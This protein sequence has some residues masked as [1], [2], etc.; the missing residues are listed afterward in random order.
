MDYQEWIQN[1]AE[2]LALE[3]YG[4]E[5]QYLPSNLRELVYYKAEAQYRNYCA[6][7][8]GAINDRIG[9]VVYEQR[10]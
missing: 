4:H 1:R 6:M 8:L 5:Y 3:L 10:L 9:G 7:R 2:E